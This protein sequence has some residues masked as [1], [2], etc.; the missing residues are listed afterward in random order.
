MNFRKEKIFSALLRYYFDNF[1][2]DLL[3]EALESIDWEDVNPGDRQQYIE[4]CAVRHCYKKAMDGIMSFRIRRH[5]RKTPFA[6]II[7][8]LCTAEK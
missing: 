2:G 7:R 6:N 8:L 1:E 3:D 5:R 4:Y